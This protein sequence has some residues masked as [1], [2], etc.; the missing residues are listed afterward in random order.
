M[1][2]KLQGTG[3]ET[4]SPNQLYL[5]DVLRMGHMAGQFST[6]VGAS[7]G[8]DLFSVVVRKAEY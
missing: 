3:Q 7:W 8:V 2:P 5:I 1:S 4:Q 6:V